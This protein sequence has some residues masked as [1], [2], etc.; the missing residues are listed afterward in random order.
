MFAL[1]RMLIEEAGPNPERLA[2]A[3]HEQ[4]TWQSGPVPVHEIAYAL[5]IVQIRDSPANGFEGALVMMP[6]RGTGSI[7]VNASSSPQ[8]RRFTIAHELGH[9]L[10]PWHQPIGSDSRFECTR[11]D[12]LT[13]WRDMPP[14][15]GRR[16]RQEAEANRFAIEL[17]APARRLRQYVSGIPDLER[18]VALSKALDISKEAGARRYV[19]LLDQPTAIVFGQAGRVR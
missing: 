19:E 15:A 2:A 8:R 12:L 17:L 5:D 10:N 1:D 4:L 6:D 7:A 18:V 3:I 14:D 11:A 9:F 16:R 13:S